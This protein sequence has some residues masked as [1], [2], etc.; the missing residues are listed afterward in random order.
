MIE[1]LVAERIEAELDRI[2]AEEGVRI[3]YA[4]ESGSRAWGFA[5]TD[6]DYDV[7]FVYLRPTAW[8]LTID[9]RRDSLERP[10]T[11]DLDLA[12]WDLPKALGLF[13]KSN[14]PLGEWLG[15]PIVYREV[16]S[17]AQRLRDLMPAYHSPVGSFHHY[18]SM[19]TG[20]YRDYL[21][22]ELVKLTKYLYVLR[23]T[24]ACLWIERGLGPVPTEFGRLTERLIDDPA[25]TAAIDDLLAVKRAGGEMDT[26]P[27]VAVI[28]DWLDAQIERL[29]QVRPPAP[30]RTDT[31]ALDALWH[32][33]LVETWG[34]WP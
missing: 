18:L 2:E 9:H 30:P 5:S 3:L 7:R 11:D 31:A 29:G 17:A 1:P 23:P 12:G 15:S 4:C 20:N 34:P 32:E 27:R 25:L 6:S 19:A 13:R 33:V 24:L 21:R 14:P 22:G 10:I 8:Y 28:S 16:G 26:A